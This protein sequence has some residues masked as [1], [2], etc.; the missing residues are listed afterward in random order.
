VVGLHGQLAETQDMVV[1]H[2]AVKPHN[3]LIESSASLPLHRQ[4]TSESVVGKMKR[5]TVF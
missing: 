3:L 4:V 2:Q 1:R 5:Q